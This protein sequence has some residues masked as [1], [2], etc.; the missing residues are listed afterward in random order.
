MAKN[1]RIVVPM[2]YAAA[3]MAGFLISSTA[4]TAVTIVGAMVLGALFVLTRGG[5]GAAVE[6]GRRPPRNRRA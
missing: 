4:G 5:S 1:L 3:V 6:G 2:L